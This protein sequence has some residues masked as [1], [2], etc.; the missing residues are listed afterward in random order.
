MLCRAQGIAALW[1]GLKFSLLHPPC[2]Q[3]A[4]LSEAFQTEIFSFVTFHL[5]LD[6]PDAS[7]TPSEGVRQREGAGVRPVTTHG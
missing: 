7:S 1:G 4:T 3:T 5:N 2:A 6:I